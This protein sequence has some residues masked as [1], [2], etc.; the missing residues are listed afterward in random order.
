MAYTTALEVQSILAD[1]YDA[2]IAPSLDPFIETANQLI[3]EVCAP[4]GYTVG[5]LAEI[6]K[7]LAAH[8]YSVTKPRLESEG[9]GPIQNRIQS[10]VDTGLKVTHWGQQAIVLDTAGGL[11]RLASQAEGKPQAKTASVIYLGTRRD[12]WGR[13]Y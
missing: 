13:E 4:A 11:A 3:E 6:E 2:L 9:V 8:F 1:E 5:R 7:Y 10:K 12:A